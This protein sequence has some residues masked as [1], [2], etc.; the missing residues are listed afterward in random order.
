MNCNKFYWKIQRILRHEHSNDQ[1][2]QVCEGGEEKRGRI[3]GLQ[4]FRLTKFLKVLG[5]E[6]F[7]IFLYFITG[8]HLLAE[9]TVSPLKAKQNKKKKKKKPRSLTDANKSNWG[10]LS[11]SADLSKW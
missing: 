3:L 8:G 11:R 10:R 4:F 1:S 5:K 2:Y 9:Y 7:W 6:E